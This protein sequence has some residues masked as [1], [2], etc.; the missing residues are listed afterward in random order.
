MSCSRVVLRYDGTSVIGRAAEA[1][2]V[3]P[4]YISRSDEWRHALP[5]VTWMIAQL[6]SGGTAYEKPEWDDDAISGL[7]D[8]FYSTSAGAPFTD[9]DYRD[10]LRQLCDT[11]SGDPWRWSASRIS[12]I[13]RS[14]ISYYDVPLEIA[15]DAAALLRAYVPF[16]HADSGIRRELTDEAIATIDELSLRYR[17]KLLHDRTDYY[18]EGDIA[19]PPWLTYPDRASCDG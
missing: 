4:E 8:A 6:P 19:P 13:L 18:D 5:L 3:L 12:S 1:G 16:A 9:I 14:S 15:F 11:G 17:Q 2:T 7:L 10:F